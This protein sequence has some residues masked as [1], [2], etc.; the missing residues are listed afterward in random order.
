MLVSETSSTCRSSQPCSSSR[1]SII[2]ACSRSP[3]TGGL[4]QAAAGSPL[5]GQYNPDAVGFV[6]RPEVLPDSNLV[7]AFEPD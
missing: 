3:R 6:D 2:V 7:L 1:L 4:V 5:W